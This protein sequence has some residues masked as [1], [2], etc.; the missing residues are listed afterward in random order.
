MAKVKHINSF[1]KETRKFI[2]LRSSIVLIYTM[3]MLAIFPFYLKS[4]SS[5]REDKYHF[6]VVIT[7]IVSVIIGALFLI[8]IGSR[9]KGSAPLIVYCNRPKFNLVDI[10]LLTFFAINII[11]AIFASCVGAEFSVFFSGSNG[12]NM[13]LLTLTMLVL[14]YFLISRLF[15]F[16]KSIFG[17]VLIGMSIMSFIAIINYYY[18]DPLYL[19]AKYKMQPKVINN[20]TTTIGNKNYL[21]AM[22]CVALPF[23][24]GLAVSAKEKFTSIVAYISVGIQFMALIVATS[25]GGFL[26][27]FVGIAIILLYSSRDLKKLSKFFVCATIMVASAKLLWIFD[28]IMDGEN[29][30]YVSLSKLFIYEHSLFALIPVFA[31]L[32]LVFAKFANKDGKI[33]KRLFVSIGICLLVILII[34]TA[35]F[36]IYTNNKNLETN[37]FTSYFRF[38]EDWGTH[39][40]F[41]WINSFEMF[42]DFSFSEKLFGVGPDNFEERFL[43]F[44]NELIE[45]YNETHADAAHNV[46]I[47]YLITSG[48]LGCVAYLVFVVAVLKDAFRSALKNPMAFA[49]LGAVVA[50]IVQDIVNIA[51][52]VNT[53][54]LFVII[55]LS[56]ASFLKNNSVEEIEESF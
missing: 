53:P 31:L 20:F 10:S 37:E 52:P 1:D 19:F 5:C 22:I 11:S 8:N 40:G 26:G 39:R 24:I 18:F 41:F 25:D 32:A 21:S 56:Q 38:N 9:P 30:G 16:N 54:W 7:I 4:Y 36:A 46:Y 23:A 50:Y 34:I 3:M 14:C 49:L 55:A 27:C 28:L 33:A 6:F 29:K 43:V 17:I 51:N 35:F 42:R 13:G 2:D 45:K 12:R 15:Y 47:N 48:I 44:D